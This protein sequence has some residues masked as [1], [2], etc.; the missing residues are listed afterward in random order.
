MVIAKILE[1]IF[2]VPN[3]EVKEENVEHKKLELNEKQVYE[4]SIV[5]TF[6]LTVTVPPSSMILRSENYREFD[7]RI[8]IRKISIYFP[9]GCQ[10]LVKVLIGVGNSY[11][12]QNWIVSSDDK[13]LEI[14]PYNTI[15]EQG[16]I[17]WA[18]VINEDVEYPHKVDIDFEAQYI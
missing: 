17:V 15:V 9:P 10:D 3:R 4:S 14:T 5:F 12:T 13:R 18:E 7:R 1:E 11:I 16:T 8:K 6:S 2:K